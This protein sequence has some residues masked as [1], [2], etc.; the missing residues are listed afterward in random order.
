MKY[1]ECKMQINQKYTIHKY[2]PP[3][4]AAL[5]VLITNSKSRVIEYFESLLSNVKSMFHYIS[6]FPKVLQKK[7]GKVLI[8]EDTKL[9]FQWHLAFLK[10]IS[11]NNNWRNKSKRANGLVFFFFFF[12]AAN[13][14]NP[15]L[16]TLSD[17]EVF[18]IKQ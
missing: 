6:L 12:T 3:W 17:I 18:M 15:V 10:D 4:A 2:T 1:L 14:Q 8:H 16:L 7:H 11:N 9:A 5:L 13:W